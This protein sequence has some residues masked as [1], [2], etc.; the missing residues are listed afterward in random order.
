MIGEGILLSLTETIADRHGRV[1]AKACR[2]ITALP[3][4][5]PMS[6]ASYLVCWPY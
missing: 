4:S 5:E 1:F 2:N 6:Q 3:E